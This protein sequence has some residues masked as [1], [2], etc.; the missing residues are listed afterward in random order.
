MQINYPRHWP[1]T[2]DEAIVIQQQLRIQVI[3]SDHI[4]TVNYVAGVDVGFE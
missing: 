4:S 1:E 3:T 2:A